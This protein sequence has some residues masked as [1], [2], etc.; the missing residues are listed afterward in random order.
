MRMGYFI[1]TLSTQFCP[2]L[3]REERATKWGYIWLPACVGPPSHSRSGRKCP[4]KSR[5]TNC[6]GS[7]PLSPSNGLPA[8]GPPLLLVLS[9]IFKH[10][11]FTSP[12]LSAFKASYPSHLDIPPLPLQSFSFLQ[13]N[14]SQSYFNKLP[15]CSLSFASRSTPLW[16]QSLPITSLTRVTNDFHVAESNG[17]FPVL[18]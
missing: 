7:H 8:M 1:L 13:P 2:I 11:H 6:S 17:V 12:Y 4:K 15:P 14:V 9:C 3:H 5:S 18:S 16:L 10:P